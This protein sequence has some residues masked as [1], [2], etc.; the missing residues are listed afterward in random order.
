[1]SS[2]CA[3][4]QGELPARD[5]LPLPVVLPLA[6]TSFGA[7]QVLAVSKR[8]EGLARVWPD[9][10]KQPMLTHGQVVNEF[11]PACS[12]LWFVVSV[13]GG[14]RRGIGTLRKRENDLPRALLSIQFGAVNR[15]QNAV[16][17]YPFSPTTR[18]E[19]TDYFQNRGPCGGSYKRG[20]TRAGAGA[21]SAFPHRLEDAMDGLPGHAQLVA[22]LTERQ[23][24]RPQGDNAAV[25]LQ[26]A[27]GGRWASGHSPSGRCSFGGGQRGSGLSEHNVTRP[28]P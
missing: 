25:Q 3:P 4:E 18:A 13:A 12:L 24:L 7:W 11:G 1:L 6:S 10:W 20:P 22:D 17:C 21:G 15:S 14:D 19:R 26:V 9:C 27:G 28:A 2:F 16:A 23:P 8:C 5:R